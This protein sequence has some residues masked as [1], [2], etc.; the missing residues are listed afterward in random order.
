MFGHL[1]NFSHSRTTGEA[2]GFYLFFT[3]FLVG[4]STVMLPL[5]GSIGV[6]GGTGGTI[7]GGG[8]VHTMIGSL[9]V[10]ILSSL[11]LVGKKLTGDLLSIILTVVG[12]GLA[13][14]VN[15]LLGMIV[16][17]YLTTLKTK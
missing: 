7:V 9:F 4:L 17:S 5:L 16:V 1:T 10:L 3:V 2:I 15:I 12:V 13:Y 8:V 14:K 11:I 6:I